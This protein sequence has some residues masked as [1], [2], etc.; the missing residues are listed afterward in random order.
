[1]AQLEGIL[2]ELQRQLVAID[3]EKTD[4]GTALACAALVQQEATEAAAEAG[5]AAGAAGG[6]AAAAAKDQDTG[7]LLAWA[8]GVCRGAAAFTAE[9]PPSP[10]GDD[11]AAEALHWSRVAAA[12]Y[13]A[14]LHQWRR[15]KTSSCAARRQLGKL[16]AAAAAEGAQPLAGWHPAA[17]DGRQ[18]KPSRAERRGFVAAREL[19]G[20]GCQIVSFNG[21]DEKRALLPHLLA[22]DRW[23]L[24]CVSVPLPPAPSC[25]GGSALPVPCAAWLL[26]ARGMVLV[27]SLHR[28]SCLPRPFHA[29]H[30]EKQAVV[31]GVAG[32]WQWPHAVPEVAPAPPGW[33]SS[34]SAAAAEHGSASTAGGQAA[35]G[36]VDGIEAVGAQQAQIGAT[37]GTCSSWVHKQSLEA[38]QA[39][40][41]EL[42][43]SQLLQQLLRP[44]GD[45]G[46]SSGPLAA[47]DCA[48]WRLVVAGHGV[49]GGAAALLAPKLAGMH[50]GEPC[51][52]SVAQL[53]ANW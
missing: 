38:S 19:L 18:P 50:L 40:L 13:G 3:G 4:A 21:G 33:L 1:M 27:N 22:V 52:A 28:P 26:G 7:P 53:L 24:A 6:G 46:A 5:A 31:L 41:Q 34:S 20:P 29:P 42:E 51:C 36:G 12:P 25:T 30:R 43:R 32:S 9:A 39:L 49:G 44:A 48:G 11:A 14:R 37:D 45:A 10:A 15:G 17:A 16:A 35:A 47:L 23:A 8:E 2:T